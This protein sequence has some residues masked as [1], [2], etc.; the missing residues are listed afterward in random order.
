MEWSAAFRFVER[1]AAFRFVEW[2]AAFRAAALRAADV[3]EP[4][5]KEGA[6]R[7]AAVMTLLVNRHI[8]NVLAHGAPAPSRLCD[9]HRHHP[10]DEIRDGRPSRFSRIILSFVNQLDTKSRVAPG[11]AEVFP[12]PR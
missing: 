10:A 1:S 9:T 6:A 5:A 3:L 8:A 11:R 2:S 7:R 4:T 12:V